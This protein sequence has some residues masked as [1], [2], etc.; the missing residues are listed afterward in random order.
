MYVLINYTLFL[1]YYVKVNL[2]TT[3]AEIKEVL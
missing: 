2:L 1:V 3:N